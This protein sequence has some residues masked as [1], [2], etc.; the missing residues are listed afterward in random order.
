[1][2][3]KGELVDS[4]G[5]TSEVGCRTLHRSHDWKGLAEKSGTQYAAASYTFN[6]RDKGDPPWKKWGTEP[7][8]PT[9][10]LSK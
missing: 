4:P 1:M 10:F 8:E 7:G 2:R 9:L 5:S 3:R 6:M